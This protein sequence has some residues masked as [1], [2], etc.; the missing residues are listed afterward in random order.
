MPV[1]KVKGDYK[2]GSKGKV[3]KQRSKAVKQCRAIKT[4]RRN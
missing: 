1:K 2:Y 3:Y 4:S